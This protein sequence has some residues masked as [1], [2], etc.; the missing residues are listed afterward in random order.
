VSHQIQVSLSSLE[1]N[2]I[3]ALLPELSGSMKLDSQNG[4]VIPL[5][6]EQAQSILHAIKIDKRRNR[7]VVIRCLE[8][9]TQ[10]ITDAVEDVQGIGAI[11]IGERLYQF[12]ITLLDF[13]PLIWRRIQVKSC[14]LDK[15]H[16]YI[17]TAMGWTNS[18]LHQ[19]KISG[20]RYGDPELLDDGFADDSFIN[21]TCIKL[22]EVIP[23]SGKRLNFEYEYDFGDGW[24]HEIAF[25]GCLKSEKGMRYPICLEGKNAC[26]PE[27]VG[28]VYGYADYLEAI[29]DPNHEQHEDMIQWGGNFDPTLFDAEKTTN[30]MRRRLPDW[31][32]FR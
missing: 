25:E 28:G 1:R 21:S 18:H 15:L 9:I 26:P 29:A 14:T 5:S 17:Q 30:K 23:K 3:A 31:R 16:E 7:G 24:K 8:R 12:K 27:D 10:L 19:F 11:P 32:K 6:V 20:K 22:H 13:K 4:R 2:E